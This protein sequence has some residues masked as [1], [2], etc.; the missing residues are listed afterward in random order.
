MDPTR[1]ALG[2]LQRPRRFQ[3]Q[4]QSQERRSAPGQQLQGGFVKPP[5]FGDVNRFRH[6]GEAASYVTN[7][8]RRWDEESP[9]SQMLFR[10]TEG[11]RA[12]PRGEATPGQSG[13]IRGDIPDW[14]RPAPDLSTP[15]DRED[16]MPD[17]SW[18][19]ARG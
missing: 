5:D 3:A 14:S 8:R 7:N 2:A 10:G 9:Y 13:T 1:A 6:T 17:P 4:P 19:W 11:T 16:G 18:W 15:L 12:T